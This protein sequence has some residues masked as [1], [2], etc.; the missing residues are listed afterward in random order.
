MR[1][2][3]G[4]H[5]VVSRCRP[6]APID[7][8]GMSAVDH[9]RRKPSE[10]GPGQR[11][12]DNVARVVH[13]GVYA[14]VRNECG[15]TL[16]RNRGRREHVTDPG[17]ESEGRSRVARRERGRDR[18]PRL[19]REGTCL[20]A[21][22]GRRRPPS[23]LITR[24]TTAAVTPTDP[25]PTRRRGGLAARRRGHDRRRCEP[26]AGVI[27]GAGEA[28][29]RPVERGSR[30]ACDRCVHRHV[31]SLGVV[32]P[33]RQSRRGHVVGSGGVHYGVIL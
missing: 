9:M 7:W 24:L 19:A 26:Q 15:E 18:H 13:P 32:K 29:H 8:K 23:G 1:A 4:R 10:N 17:R 5:R 6:R 3:L 11:P 16:Q 21:R 2:D 27:G 22:S 31:D 12:G 33:R 20:A 25:R 30:R 28:C 14:R